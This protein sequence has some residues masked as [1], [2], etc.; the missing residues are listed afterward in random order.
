MGIYNVFSFLYC[1]GTKTQTSQVPA[2]EHLSPAQTNLRFLLVR[3]HIV[4][5]RP[6]G[7]ANDGAA[8]WHA[9]TTWCLKRWNWAFEALQ[10]DTSKKVL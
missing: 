8:G 5:L 4:S 6:V 1:L 10:F 3:V 2:Y 7:Q 9:H